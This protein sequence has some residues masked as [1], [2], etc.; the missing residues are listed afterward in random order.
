[1]EE[2][3]H[4]DNLSCGRWRLYVQLAPPTGPSRRRPGPETW[5]DA[6]GLRASL[7]LPGPMNGLP[8]QLSN[9]GNLREER[10]VKKE[11]ELTWIACFWDPGPLKSP[12]CG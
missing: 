12:V 6:S 3:S 8:S 1:M 4:S 11:C 7:A 10:Q 5:S 2:G 9:F